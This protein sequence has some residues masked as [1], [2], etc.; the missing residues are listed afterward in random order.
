MCQCDGGSGGFWFYL[1][2][3]LGTSISNKSVLERRN[4]VIIGGFSVCLFCSILS[5]GVPEPRNVS[6]TLPRPVITWYHQTSCYFMEPFKKM[7][8]KN[9]GNINFFRQNE[10]C[11][12]S[13]RL[14]N[15]IE[16]KHHDP[17]PYE[18]ILIMW[19][20]KHWCSR[21]FSSFLLSSS[22]FP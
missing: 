18:H 22:M 3:Q 13:T 11:M 21:F 1:S 4:S 16:C 15:Y 8:K 2:L 19:H 12:N 20:E 9:D 14:L 17:H 6:V 10:S 5:L 7:E